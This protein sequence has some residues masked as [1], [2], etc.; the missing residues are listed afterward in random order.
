M[1]AYQGQVQLRPANDVEHAVIEKQLMGWAKTLVGCMV[2]V[3]LLGGIVLIHEFWQMNKEGKGAA[4]FI[5]VLFYLLVLVIYAFI[6]KEMLLPIIRIPKRQYLVVDCIV[7]DKKRKAA[8]K[9]VR[10]IATVSY[11]D[12]TAQ[13]VRVNTPQIYEKAQIGQHAVVVWFLDRKG[14]SRKYPYSL[15]VV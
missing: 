12:G 8:G 15:S 3:I 1:N 13:Q 5:Y 4:I 6:M 9:G 2:A 10:Y 14:N 7:M 11:A